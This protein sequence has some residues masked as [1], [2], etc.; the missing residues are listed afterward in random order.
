MPQCSPHTIR[1]T[2]QTDVQGISESRAEIA[3]H[4]RRMCSHLSDPEFDQ[5]VFEVAVKLYR[6]EYGLSRARE[7]EIRQDYECSRLIP[8]LPDA[9]QA[10]SR[11]RALTR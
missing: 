9:D 5:L 10:S 3:V 11:S 4:L 6:F 7:A 2:V 1:V 8:L